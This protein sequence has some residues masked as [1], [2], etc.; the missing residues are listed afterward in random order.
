ML[1]YNSYET[2]FED[3]KE[4]IRNGK[5]RDGQYN[6]HKTRRTTIHHNIKFSS[7]FYGR[8]HHWYV[9]TNEFLVSQFDSDVFSMTSRTL[10]RITLMAIYI[11]PHSEHSI[12][13][14]VFGGMYIFR[15][16]FI[17]VFVSF[18]LLYQDYFPLVL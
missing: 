6:G 5:S 18:R 11:L 14:L 17:F 8:H 12:P 7:G 16:L 15:N 3:T 9:A 4:V 10:W 1:K 2:K 13:L